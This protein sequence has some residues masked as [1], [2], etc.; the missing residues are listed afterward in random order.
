MPVRLPTEAD[1]TS[2]QEPTSGQELRAL[3]TQKTMLCIASSSSLP[4]N[5][6]DTQIP[7]AELGLDSIMTGT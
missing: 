1:Q 3:Q 6:K 5:E 2:L 7:L 4:E